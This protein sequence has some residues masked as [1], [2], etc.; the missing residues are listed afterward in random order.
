MSRVISGS[1]PLSERKLCLRERK[2]HTRA[3]L[4]QPTSPFHLVIRSSLMQNMV[5]I[6]LVEALFYDFNFQAL[7][8]GIFKHHEIG[9]DFTVYSDNRIV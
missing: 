9:R 7:A 4:T 3:V 6:F 5:G 2:Q 8:L 1:T